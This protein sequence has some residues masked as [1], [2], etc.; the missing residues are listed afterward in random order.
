MP[1]KHL[2]K[3]GKLF[4]SNID[5]A[6]NIIFLETWGELI[7]Q[8]NIVAE[9]FSSKSLYVS[10]LPSSANLCFLGLVDLIP[11][12]WLFHSGSFLVNLKFLAAFQL[13][14]SLE[15]SI[16]PFL[17]CIVYPLLNPLLWYVSQ[18]SIFSLYIYICVISLLLYII[19]TKIKLMTAN[20]WLNPIYV[21]LK[22]RKLQRNCSK[23][24]TLIHSTIPYLNLIL[25]KLSSAIKETLII[26][27]MEHSKWD[28]T[29]DNESKTKNLI[30]L[31]WFDSRQFIRRRGSLSDL[32]IAYR[33]FQEIF[34]M[35]KVKCTHRYC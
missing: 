30:C 23:I 31:F 5:F 25:F 16:T 6:L 18:A 24:N 13:E 11:F 27:Q 15:Y 33:H 10:F 3:E 28:K 17:N 4:L 35:C 29:L 19:S 22:K 14:F 2:T 26:C 20:L 32:D 8:S 1:L 7:M 12:F 21:M 9:R 34:N